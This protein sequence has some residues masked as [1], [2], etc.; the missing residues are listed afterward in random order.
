M[1]VHVFVR[2][3]S[4][5]HGK[6]RPDWFSYESCF[7]NLLSIM[8][9]DSELTVFF[10]GDPTNHFVTKYDQKIVTTEGGT[11]TKSFTKLLDYVKALD[12]KDDDIVY[13]VEDD[14][15]HLPNSLS[16]LREIFSSSNVDYISLYDH[17]DKYMPGYF[18]H[19]ARG[20]VSQLYVTEKCHWRTTPST[21]NSYAMKFSTLKRDIDVHYKYSKTG[22]ISQDHAKF[23]ELWNIGKSLVTPIPGYSTHVENNLM[24]PTTDWIKVS[25]QFIPKD[26]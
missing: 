20:F 5:G 14:Y 19:Y 11:E 13:F 12:I 26:E 4:H 23:C 7:R 21:T 16:V 9:E 3:T 1:K 24:S 2:H 18:E 17:A 6:F 22:Y 10:D 25:E 8:D 15:L